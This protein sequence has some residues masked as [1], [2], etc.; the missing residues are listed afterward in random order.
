MKVSPQVENGHTDI[1]NEI[2]DY[3][4]GYRI[5]GEEWQVLWV[6]IRKTYGWHKKQDWVSLSQFAELTKMKKPNIIRAIKKLQEKKVIIKK[7][8]KNGRT[9]AFNKHY[10]QWK[11]LSKKIRLSKVIIPIIKSDNDLLS[12]VIPTKEK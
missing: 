8:N 9:Y 12:K 11:K 6:I 10:N 1:A 4:C 7:D 5:S 2:I 3:L